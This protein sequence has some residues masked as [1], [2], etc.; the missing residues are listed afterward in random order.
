MSTHELEPVDPHSAVEMYLKDMNGRLSP[1]TVRARDYRLSDFVEWCDGKDNGNDPRL[2]DLSELSGRDIYRY[3]NWRKDEINKVTLRTHL[4]DLRGFLRFCVTIDAVPESLP[5]KVD[6]PVL[7]D[8]ENERET[9]LDAHVAEGIID[10]LDQYYY[11]SLNHVLV[12]LLWQTGAR[13]SGMHSLDVGD[14]DLEEETIS[15]QH[16][17]DQGT[18]LKNGPDGERIVALPEGTVSVLDDYINVKREPVT[19]EYGRE[20]LFASPQGRM[21]INYLPKRVYAVTRPCQFGKQCPA[22]KDPAD[23]EYVGPID[24][25]VA[26]PHNTRPHDVRRG[27][28]THWLRQDVPEKAISDRMN[29]STKTLDNHYDTRTKSEKAEQRRQ[30]LDDV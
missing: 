18:R 15:I 9:I 29:V 27:A 17:P 13:I 12:L 2:T 14:V 16:R 6:V 19:D 5:E 1:N 20:P 7:S 28:I 22:D 4:S 25:A 21:H 26:C 11:A 24:D 30:Y 3:K 23:C 10:F 8:G